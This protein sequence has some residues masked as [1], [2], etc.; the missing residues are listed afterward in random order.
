MAQWSVDPAASPVLAAAVEALA[1]GR[2]PDL[3]GFDA[4]QV[5]Q[6]MAPMFGPGGLRPEVL[7]WLRH[8]ISARSGAAATL[9]DADRAE[10][11][12]LSK[13]WGAVYQRLRGPG[14]DQL[15]IIGDSMPPF[16]FVPHRDA[17]GPPEPAS[18]DLAPN[19]PDSNQA[20]PNQPGAE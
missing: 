5:R 20:E 19:E 9:T 18:P 11:A 17:A 8:E 13:E 15:M 16:L 3:T 6:A 7:D 2:Q 1:Q 4:D 14:F 12:W 10:F